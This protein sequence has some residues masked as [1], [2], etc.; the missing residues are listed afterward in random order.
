MKVI[1]ILSAL[2]LF[3]SSLSWAKDQ[4]ADQSTVLKNLVQEDRRLKDAVEKFIEENK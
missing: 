2:A 3:T 4:S 1:N